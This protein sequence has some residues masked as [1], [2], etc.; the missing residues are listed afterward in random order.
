MDS[1]EDDEDEKGVDTVLREGV[2]GSNGGMPPLRLD[3]A[4]SEASMTRSATTT[5]DVDDDGD[6][7]STSLEDSGV[8]ITYQ[9]QT[10]R[11]QIRSSALSEEGSVASS[12][13]D[14]DSLELS[15]QWSA[16]L[17]LAQVSSHHL[18]PSGKKRR[19]EYS[20]LQDSTQY[21][22][23]EEAESQWQATPTNEMQSQLISQGIEEETQFLDADG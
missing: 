6:H 4:S 5:N 21:I 18:S 9:D 11:A 7:R 14:G 8:A 23:E 16:S 19:K 13:A 22:L 2:S 3:S 17:P 15:L 10:D 12:T 20:P 1:D